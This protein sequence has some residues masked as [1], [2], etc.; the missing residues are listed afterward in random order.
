MKKPL[1]N[2]L[3]EELRKI[4][5]DEWRELIIDHYLKK[6]IDVGELKNVDGKTGYELNPN[7]IIFP[8]FQFTKQ[9]NIVQGKSVY[10]LGFPLG[11]GIETNTPILRS[12]LIAS[13]PKGDDFFIDAMVNHGNS[14][15]PLFT[16]SVS[17]NEYKWELAGIISA[18]LS[19]SIDYAS[20]G[21]EPKQYIR[22]SH[23]SGLARVIS[24]HT[25]IEFFRKNNGQ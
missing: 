3:N 9:E 15:S 23:N 19:D 2:K 1:E 24:I 11:I 22:L 21:V 4:S 16:V 6:M 17:T 5:N 12:G 8:S 18:S 14:G 13:V 25:I 7:V 20:V 10:F